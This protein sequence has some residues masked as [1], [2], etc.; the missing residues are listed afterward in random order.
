M[1]KEL[2][3]LHLEYKE[4][5]PPVHK[6]G[7]VGEY[8]GSG[9]GRAEGERLQ[10]EIHWTL[11]EDVSEALC[12]SN[13]FGVITT[14]DGAKIR[15]DSLGYFFVPDKQLSHKWQTS[16]AVYFETDY[17]RYAWLNRRLG[18]WQ[19]TFDMQ[20]YRHKYTVFIEDN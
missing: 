4:G 11:Y 10:G 5:K 14:E 18:S 13:L 17:Q 16:A 7:K 20:T 8:I 9:E 12:Q 6:N 3:E 1:M 2:F 15:F 19:G